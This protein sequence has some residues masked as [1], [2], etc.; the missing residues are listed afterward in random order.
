V[1]RA[2]GLFSWILV[3]FLTVWLHITQLDGFLE[4]F[5]WVIGMKVLVFLWVL[6]GVSLLRPIFTR[7]SRQSPEAKERN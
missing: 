1:A 7:Q 3:A 6:L 4:A 2:I 5:P